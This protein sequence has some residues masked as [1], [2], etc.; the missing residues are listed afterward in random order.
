MDLENFYQRFCKEG[1]DENG[2]LNYFEPVIADN[3][4]FAYDVVDEIARLEP[5]RRAMVWC[6][7][8]GEER[9]FT[10]GEM[11][12][13]SDRAAQMLADHGI[14]K[15]DMVMLVLKR[16][17][18]FWFTVL[19]LH[20]LGAVGVPGHQP[21]HHPRPRLPL[22]GRRHHRA[23]SASGR[24][25]HPRVCRRG[26]AGSIPRSTPSS[27]SAAGGRAGSTI[28]TELEKYDGTPCE[29]VPTSKDDPHAPLLHLRHHRHAQ[30][31]RSTTTPTRW[32]T[33]SPPRYWHNRRPDG[34]H[35]T[36]SET[37]WMK[38]VWG[39]LY[40]QWL[41]RP[42]SSSTT[43][44]SSCPSDLLAHDGKVQ[45]HHL[46]RAAD[47]LP[48]LHQGGDGGYDLSSLQLLPP[49]RA[50]RSTPRSYNRW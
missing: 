39:K 30:D 19:A 49:R 18:E 9:V 34:L 6:N 40:G 4:N 17:Y 20:K 41:G 48:L 43:L 14:K 1:F 22:R 29:R 25:Q 16:H 5:N 32:R 26:D 24:V 46:L 31:G 45:G 44:T 27:S 2:V 8:A 23:A 42:A 35:L 37:G 38:A 21:A 10:F 11:K 50:R 28:R 15:G 36:V 7:V 3:F 33:S 47:H 13:Y 12:H